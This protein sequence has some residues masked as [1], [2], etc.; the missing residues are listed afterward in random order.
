MS[1]KSQLTDKLTS[2]KKTRE[3][4]IRSKVSISVASQLRAIRRRQDLTQ[5]GLADLSEM[6]QS[7]ISAMERPGTRWNIETLVRL[8]AALKL[9]LVVKV[10]PFSGMLNWENAFNQDTFDPPT[11]EHDAEFIGP[12]SQDADVSYLFGA[13]SWNHNTNVSVTTTTVNLDNATFA[14]IA[15]AAPIQAEA[16]Q[17][18]QPQGIAAGA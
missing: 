1:E 16:V 9:G 10:V 11:I 18:S 5:E 8:V 4:Y 17:M 2:N 13:V 6:K 15:G 14:G 12:G 3:A 7:R